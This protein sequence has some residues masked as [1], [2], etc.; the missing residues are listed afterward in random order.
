MYTFF[1]SPE[2]GL[3]E[4]QMLDFSS[5]TPIDIFSAPTASVPMIRSVITYCKQSE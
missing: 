1:N 2:E 3:G 5:M 4:V